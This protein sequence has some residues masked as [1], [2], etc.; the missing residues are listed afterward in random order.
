M[1]PNP[2][3]LAFAAA[4]ADEKDG[5]G[6]DDSLDT[7][8]S[9]DVISHES[10]EEIPSD[11][12]LFEKTASSVAD[13]K[14]TLLI[15]CVDIKEVDRD[16][17]TKEFFETASKYL[18]SLWNSYD[19][20]TVDISGTED[21]GN[22]ADESF[23]PAAFDIENANILK[24]RENINM[25]LLGSLYAGYVLDLTGLGDKNDLLEE[26]KI[27]GET[28]CIPTYEVFYAGFVYCVLG[29]CFPCANYY[30]YSWEIWTD[31]TVLLERDFY[32]GN[33]SVFFPGH[34]VRVTFKDGDSV[35]FCDLSKYDPRGQLYD[36]SSD[37]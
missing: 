22:R 24:K 32:I 4:C 34:E 5:N 12:T 33:P 27:D 36:F 29:F 20:I 25:C 31:T 26:I 1:L 30:G 6:S 13:G 23:A 15:R 16:D 8:S 18:Q 37:E 3:L 17:A 28:V 9:E 35:L 19:Y 14:S 21:F 2:L 10:A 11:F 7:A